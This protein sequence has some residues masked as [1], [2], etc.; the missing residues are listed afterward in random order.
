MM[1]SSTQHINHVTVF[2]CDQHHHHI[3]SSNSLLPSLNA[4]S[5]PVSLNLIRSYKVQ[6]RV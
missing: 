5:L 3:V 1:L 6:R 2:G 4:F